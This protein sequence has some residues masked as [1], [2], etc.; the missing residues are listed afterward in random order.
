MKNRPESLDSPKAEPPALASTSSVPLPSPETIMTRITTVPL[1]PHGQK[2]DETNQQIDEI[3]GNGKWRRSSPCANLGT[4]SGYR[5]GLDIGNGNIGWCVLFEDGHKVRLLDA[6]EI[7]A[8]NRKLG[9]KQT[10]TQLP[11]GF[12]PLGTH[13]FD[14]RDPENQQSNASIRAAT[15]AQRRT[16]KTRQRRKRRLK[17]LLRSIGLWPEKGHCHQGH[18]R[19]R[20]GE[21]RRR[22]VEEGSGF[23]A[24]PHDLGRA[25]Y[26]TIKKRGWMPPVGRLGE[27]D[28]A[29]KRLAKTIEEKFCRTLT[30]FKCPTP[31]VF[32]E[33][34]AEDAKRDRRPF[35]RRYT[36]LKEKEK[37]KLDGQAERES[38]KSYELFKE[39]T[40]TLALTLKEVRLLIKQSGIGAAQK[41]EARIISEAKSRNPLKGTI[42]GLCKHLPDFPRCPKALPSYQ[43]FR[44][45]EAADN[46]RAPDGTCLAPDEHARIIKTLENTASITLDELEEETG[47]ALKGKGRQRGRR[48]PGDRTRMAMRKA[49]GEAWDR[50][51]S[52]EEQNEWITRLLRRHP[53][54]ANDIPPKWTAEDEKKLRADAEETFGMPLK[55]I[56]RIIQDPKGLENGFGHISAKAADT[57]AECHERQEPVENRLAALREIDAPEPTLELHDELPY[58][59]VILTRETT[60]AR[61]FGPQGS[62]TPDELEHGR[63]RN[64]GVH[65]NLNRL[66][67]VVNAV[68]GMMGGIFPTRISVEVA[69]S[70]MSDAEAE[71]HMDSARNRER[72]REKIIEEI[73]EAVDGDP[74]PHG[75]ALE[76]A[77]E[78]WKAAMR[79]GWRDYD[80]SE[81]PRSQLLDETAYELDHVEPA[82]L[83]DIRQNNMFV[84]RFNQDK[85]K[86]LPWKAFGGREEWRPALLAF[87]RFGTEQRVKGVEAMRRSAG[88][89]DKKRLA[90][91]LEKAKADL[92]KLDVLGAPDPHLLN[93]LRKTPARLKKQ[94][95][96]K[97]AKARGMGRLFQRFHPEYEARGYG[98][99]GDGNHAKYDAGN[100]AGT[101]KLALRYLEVLGADVQAVRPRDVHALRCAFGINKERAD[102]RN[103]AVDAFLAGNI[104]NRVLGPAMTAMSRDRLTKLEKRFGLDP[105][106]RA[107][108]KLKNGRR[109]DVVENIENGLQILDERI[110]PYMHTAHRPDH[111][112]NPGDPMESGL[113]GIGGQNLYRWAPD[114]K[115]MKEVAEI[116]DPGNPPKG[117]TAIMEKYEKLN[118]RQKA[119]VKIN[120]MKYRGLKKKNRS[121]E[122]F[123][124]TRTNS[125]ME[126]SSKFGLEIRREGGKTK[127]QA[128]TLLTVLEMKEA[129]REALFANGTMILRRG[130]TMVENGKA[131]VVKGA[132]AE[133]RIISWPC[134]TASGNDLPQKDKIS[135]P[136]Q[137]TRKVK[138]D[139]LGRQ[140]Y[141]LGKDHGDIE[142]VHYPLRKQLDYGEEHR[143]GEGS[144]NASG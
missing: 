116:L 36:T 4:F 111:K 123:R 85:G 143:D 57:L 113:G 141:T 16:L 13:K 97:E 115:D 28:A 31:G 2:D 104:D 95:L 66:R 41:A 34:C 102:L 72:A 114:R 60:P 78:R 46:L 43:R 83:G 126:T 130:D 89:E 65:L 106:K 121:V 50:I 76:K 7:E 24:H 92:E 74:M 134:N 5:I 96:E 118:P 93:I 144:E 129:E 22:I 67:K 11:R 107:L 18:R 70:A 131:K 48:L 138:A 58:Y 124:R 19:M 133:G 44:L 27:K 40:P 3:L 32:A 120:Q 64:P 98:E 45:R 139:V 90:K 101:T 51:D 42:P 91:V 137:K 37:V 117:K 82:A 80:G 140:L 56:D 1:P 77:I 14:N 25:L 119:S 33:K 112:W 6:D 73:R 122:G 81:I 26:N 59:G 109:K 21:L 52:I 23:K 8:H 94:G 125:Y 135:R 12:V 15:N 53:G 84:T 99:A 30:D 39:L 9:P 105:L 54:P 61:L 35:N 10:R 71:K 49:A 69:R 110:L 87:A 142:P 68:I 79:Q 86:H 38:R 75:A 20:P 88:K 136:N 103:H 128:I 62:I 63:I 17:L 29:D 127:R 47:I 108:S 55:D 100:I 132:T